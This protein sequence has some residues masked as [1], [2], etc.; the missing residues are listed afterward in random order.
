MDEAPRPIYVVDTCS[1]FLLQTHRRRTFGRLW[2]RLDSLADD[3]R[4]LVP[5]EVER[6]L[7]D[8]DHEDAVVWVRDHRTTV[9]VSTAQLWARSQEVAGRY[10]KPGLVD[11]AKPSGTADPFLIALALEE[12]DRQ[13]ATLWESPV[14]V[15]TEERTRRPGRVAIPDACDD[16]GLEV[17]NLQ[18]LF[19]SEGWEDL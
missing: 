19:D 9:V 15:I 4:F 8:D 11:L 13:R 6:E 3:R 10:P 2:A 17:G 16:Y 14:K 5:E 7:G 12:R 1:L 18:S